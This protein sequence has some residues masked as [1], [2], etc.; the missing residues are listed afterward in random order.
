MTSYS[1]I[2]PTTSTSLIRRV[3]AG[4]QEAW[5]RFVHL[6]SG[7]IYSKCRTSELSPEDSADILQDVFRRVHT[8]VQNYSPQKDTASFRRW[9]RTV[10]TSAI[11]EHFR[12][13][14]KRHE[15]LDAAT[16]NLRLRE[17]TESF[18]IDS[19]SS[20]NASAKDGHRQTTV[21]LTANILEQIRIDYEENTWKAFWRTTID[22]QKAID[23]AEELGMTHGAVRTATYTVRRRLR[24]ELQDLL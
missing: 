5:E 3:K 24:D 16:L 13:L 14:A 8:G 18:S 11:A 20:M 6:Y 22:G 15:E 7:L 9:L 21:M 2:E 23:V 17:I 10:A 19:E 12:A 4:D 1:D